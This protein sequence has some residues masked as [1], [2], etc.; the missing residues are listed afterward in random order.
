[1]THDNKWI[2]FNR[3]EAEDIAR[4]GIV[5]DETRMKGWQEGWRDANW[6]GNYSPIDG[7]ELRRPI[8]LCNDEIKRL[9]GVCVESEHFI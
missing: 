9:A 3:D 2:Y 7:F 8:A 4:V 1:M 5:G 6:T